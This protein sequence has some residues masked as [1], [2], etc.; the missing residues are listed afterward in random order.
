[1]AAGKKK[2]QSRPKRPEYQVFVSHATPD[3]WIAKRICEAIESTGATTFRDDR[4]IA[5]GDD[6]PDTIRKSII[7]SKEMVVVLTPAS[8]GRPWVILEIG[9]AMGRRQNYRVSPILYH[10]DTRAI[11]SLIE[12]K[13]AFDLNDFADYVVELR[14]RVSARKKAK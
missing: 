7:E 3:K 1:M 9:M 2:R 14:R 4:D 8:S 13:R 5:G 6:I 10:T 11:P 12:A